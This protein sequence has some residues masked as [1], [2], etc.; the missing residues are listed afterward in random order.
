MPRNIENGAAF[1]CTADASPPVSSYVW[2]LVPS[3]VVQSMSQTL[4]LTEDL[5]FGQLTNFG[6]V[7][8][9]LLSL[10]HSSEVKNKSSA[11]TGTWVW[12]AIANVHVV[13]LTGKLQ[14][15]WDERMHF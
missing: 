11:G 9:H 14:G 8:M 6:H 1:T 7:V 5:V 4:T 13:Q 15:Y 12:G 10:G 2:T 3:G